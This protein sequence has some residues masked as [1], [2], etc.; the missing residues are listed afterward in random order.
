MIVRPSAE[1]TSASPPP[2]MTPRARF[3]AACRSRPVDRTPVWFMRQAGSALA[4][5]RELRDRHGVAGIAHDADLAGQV[6]ALP[7]AELGVDAAILF[8]DIMLMLEPMGVELEL[9][10]EGPRLARPLR[11]EDDVR[12]LRPLD[13]EAALGFVLASIRGLRGEL[14]ERAAI[15]GLA[16]GPFTLAGYLVE[17]G[18]SRDM[19]HTRAWMHAQPE[20][21]GRLLERLAE[22]VN[23]YLGAQLAAGADAVQL[24]DSWVGCLSPGDY[25]EYVQPHSRAAIAG[26][27]ADVPVIH[28]GTNTG[29]LLADMRQAGGDVI[30]ADWRL[31]L[32][33]AWQA[34]GHDRAVQGNLDPVA[35]F[36][37][38]TE[39]RRRAADI[40]R[41][42]AGRPGHIF[43]LG[44]GILP[45]TPVDHVVALVDA[46]HEM[47]SRGA[48]RTGEGAPAGS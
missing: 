18:P 22:S 42:A 32:D 47:S 41:R 38:P 30:G 8:A 44:H 33:A 31:D 5:Y 6:A 19:V 21:F 40:L 12:R 4:S 17:G 36:A 39:I 3:L 2:A 7:V 14:G 15:I 11:T 25:R 1:R 23:A 45:E 10:R 28:F 27:G 26:L 46:V 29:G 20:V 37:S 24:F 35:L 34:I 9:T 13:P 16:G 43:N 48:G